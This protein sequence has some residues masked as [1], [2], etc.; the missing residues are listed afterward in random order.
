MT[1]EY[2]ITTQTLKNIAIIEYS[3]AII[4]STT[5]LQNWQTQLETEAKA[6]TITYSLQ[7]GG[8]NVHFEAVK[9]YLNKMPTKVSPDVASYEK[10]LNQIT[11][12]ALKKDFDQKEIR[13]LHNTLTGKLNYRS[14]T[15]ETYK[16]TTN[17][18][19]I[20]AEMTELIDWH[21]SLDARETHP[22]VAAAVFKAKFDLIRPFETAHSL[23]SDL[24]TI[25]ALR[26]RGF[27]INKYYA[28]EEYFLQ[29]QKTY[30]LTLQDAYE[31]D[32]Y[33]KWIDYF[34]DGFSREVSTIAENIKILAR[35]TKVAKAAG[36]TRLTDRQERLVTY[37]QDYGM[38]QNKDF[39]ALFPGISE[40][41]VLR[42]L[43]DLMKKGIVVKAGKTK[44]SRYELT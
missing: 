22:V 43:K 41:T 26:S 15:I 36:T 11:E 3:R 21:N 18:Q 39:P 24:V 12:M 38:L 23:V 2:T 33:T 14:K 16:W 34:T 30:E 1:P 28:L 35:D 4:E 19:E 37:L 10:A 44:S 40:D 7:R 42:E 8:I 20:L 6:R 9:R 17:P 32:D 29:T 25:L 5:I 27:A 13:E 31:N